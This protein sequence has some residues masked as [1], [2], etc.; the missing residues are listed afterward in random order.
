MA[1]TTLTGT[2]TA[3]QKGDIYTAPSDKYAKV[4]VM[5]FG[6]QYSTANNRADYFVDIGYDS[7]VTCQMGVDDVLMVEGLFP[8]SGKQNS[9]YSTASGNHVSTGFPDN[10][11]IVPPSKKIAVR[12]YYAGYQICYNFIIEEIASTT[13]LA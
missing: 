7:S 9:Q 11:F 5:Y 6:L 1:K 12:K 4:T 13:V 10:S 2:H 8:Y 3:T